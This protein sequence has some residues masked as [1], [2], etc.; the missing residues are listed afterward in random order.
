MNVLT[1]FGGRGGVL[2]V[3]GRDSREGEAVLMTLNHVN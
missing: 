3:D 1:S 2:G